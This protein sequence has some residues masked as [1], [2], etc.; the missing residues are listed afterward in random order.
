MQRR[1]SE[2]SGQ[3]PA[4]WDRL[5]EE[6]FTG[7]REWRLQHQTATLTEIETA[8]DARWARARA[9]IV[10]DVA[11]QSQARDLGRV[12]PAQRP[13][14]PDCGGQLTVAGLE[15]RVLTTTYEQPIPLH[16]SAAVCTACG[17]RLFPPG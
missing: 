11:H 14:C 12:P 7:L 16:R 8:L 3:E 6:V 4:G 1:T 13:V 2:P 9:R 15:D 10:A 17:R 5:A